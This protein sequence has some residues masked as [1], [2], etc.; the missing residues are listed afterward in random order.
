VNLGFVIQTLAVGGAQRAVVAIANQMVDRGMNVTLYLL[1]QDSQCAYELDTRVEVV[2]TGLASD[3]TTVL[4]AVK[5]N[6]ARI[7]GLRRALC[8]DGI[9]VVVGMSYSVN[10][11]VSLATIGTEILPIGSERS[12]PENAGVGF[13]WRQVRSFCYARLCTLVCLTRETADWALAN[14]RVRSVEVI[15][16]GID[17]PL[18][19]TS[20]VVDIPAEFSERQII[21]SVGRLVETKQFDQLIVA[22]SAVEKSNPNWVLAVAGD[23]P[24]KEQLE[25]QV[26]ELG[27]EQ[28]VFLLGN[29]GNLHD[30]YTTADVFVFLSNIEGF[31]NSLLEAMAYG[32]ACISY[33]CK[34][35]PRDLI[36][37]GVNGELIP[38]DALEVVVERLQLVLSDD[39]YRNALSSNAEKTRSSFSMERAINL[40]YQLLSSRQVSNR[41]GMP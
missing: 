24:L 29:V 25:R 8:T 14:T 22:Y 28:R 7:L 36:E 23:G 39:E 38:V 11:L 26:V 20:P 18:V 19:S 13:L 5:N 35:G 4:H 2:A 12:H 21:L 37:P 30:W 17:L 16:N 41:S 32:L 1:S 9:D 10:V 15:P 27:L 3:S 31:P 33:D 40:W 6:I 34:T